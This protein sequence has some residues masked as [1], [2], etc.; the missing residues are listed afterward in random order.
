[1]YKHITQRHTSNSCPGDRCGSLS[2]GLKLSF[3]D[4]LAEDFLSRPLFSSKD[5]VGVRSDSKIF[6]GLSSSSSSS[7]PAAA[8]AAAAMEGGR[9]SSSSG[10]RRKTLGV[11]RVFL[12]LDDDG[13]PLLVGLEDG[14]GG[15]D[16]MTGDF[17]R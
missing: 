14:V 17:G 16:A 13:G 10:R 9:V 2:P 15:V 11:E 5:V 12:L 8:A 3:G 4:D 7:P 1:M 6:C